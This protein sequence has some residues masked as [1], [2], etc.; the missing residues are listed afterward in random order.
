MEGL[1]ARLPAQQL[2]ST[3]WVFSQCRPVVYALCEVSG[4]AVPSRPRSPPPATDAL[5]APQVLLGWYLVESAARLCLDRP[6][7]H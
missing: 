6:L 2:D 4:Q 3:C 7:D 5:R 1:T